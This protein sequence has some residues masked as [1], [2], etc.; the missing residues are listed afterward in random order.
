MGQSGCAI[1]TLA[2]PT[3]SAPSS[4]SHCASEEVQTAPVEMR[5]MCSGTT[6][7]NLLVRLGPSSSPATSWNTSQH[8]MCSISISIWQRISAN[9][10][11]SCRKI[12]A[13]SIIGDIRTTIKKS[14]PVASRTEV[15]MSRKNLLRP[16]KSPP[17]SSSRRL[18]TLPKNWQIR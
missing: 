12:P 2:T 3:K 14:G 8:E 4:I 13:F 1:A 18:V 15:I 9:S 7:A 5:G 6:S 17:H 11:L 16:I 10:R